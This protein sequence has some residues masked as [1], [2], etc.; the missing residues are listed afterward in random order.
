M[1][2]AK[3]AVHPTSSPEHYI[4]L[5]ARG[6]RT[7]CSDPESH[8]LWLSQDESERATAT[9]LC[10]GCAVWHECGSSSQSTTGEVRRLGKRQPG[11][12][13]LAIRESH[14]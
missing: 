11:P 9:Q 14:E 6:E 12:C 8:H 10:V 4:N 5:A 13:G 2:A 3:R 7:H 1:T